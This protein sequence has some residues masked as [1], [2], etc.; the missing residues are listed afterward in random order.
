MKRRISG[1]TIAM[2]RIL[3]LAALLCSLSWTAGAQD[4]EKIDLCDERISQSKRSDNPN[5]TLRNWVLDQ[6]QYCLGAKA[7]ERGDYA[8][9]LSKI[10]PLAERGHARAQNALAFYY[11]KARSIADETFS[12]N[13]MNGSH[14]R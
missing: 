3:L 7:Y 14:F 12:R 1:N 9:A 11:A 2:K 6:N 8:A 13:G 5:H 4:L 10:R